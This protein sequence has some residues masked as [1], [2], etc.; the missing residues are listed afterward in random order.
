[1][2]E[3]EPA[4][5]E[6]ALFGLLRALEAEIVQESKKC[7]L[8]LPFIGEINTHLSEGNFAAALPLL[9]ELE[10]F[11]DYEFCGDQTYP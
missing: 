5:E 4:S 6:L 10:E 8:L 11:I 1:M 3:L 9:D 2:Q 7:A